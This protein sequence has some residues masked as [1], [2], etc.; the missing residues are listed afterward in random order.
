M[1]SAVNL[2]PVMQVLTGLALTPQEDKGLRVGGLGQQADPTCYSAPGAQSGPGCS[3]D[4]ERHCSSQGA[5][6]LGQWCQAVVP[7]PAASAPRELVRDANKWASFQT[8][9]SEAQAGR[10]PRY[11]G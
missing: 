1:V 4:R 7:R 2:V 6:G 11:C 8:Y 9:K 10:A 3:D 5:H